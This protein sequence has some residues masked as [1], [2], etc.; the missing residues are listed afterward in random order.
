M[1]AILIDAVNQNIEEVNL[2]EGKDMLQQ[3]YNTLDADMVEVA[4]YIDKYDSILVDEEGLLKP[5]DHFFSY[6]GGHQPFAGNGLIVGIDD[7]GWTVD[8]NIDIEEVV[9]NVKFHSRE[10]ILKSI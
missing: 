3:W 6:H 8:C 1:R 2:D 10:E 9:H 5:C 4:L 7:E